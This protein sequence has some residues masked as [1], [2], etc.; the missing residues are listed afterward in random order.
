MSAHQTLRSDFRMFRRHPGILRSERQIFRRLH[1][2]RGSE[3]QIFTM[4]PNSQRS[5]NRI[6]KDDRLAIAALLGVVVRMRIFS[7][8]IE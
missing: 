8:Q 6:F 2:L 3:N 5:E 1:D 7:F 4:P